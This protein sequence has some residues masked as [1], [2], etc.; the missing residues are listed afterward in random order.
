LIGQSCTFNDRE[1]FFIDQSLS[2]SGRT[3]L[4]IDE[5]PSFIGSFLR[6]NAL[7]GPRAGFYNGRGREGKRRPDND[8]CPTWEVHRQYFQSQV[9]GDIVG[10]IDYTSTGQRQ[11]T[12]F[13]YSMFGLPRLLPT[14]GVQ[15]SVCGAALRGSRPDRMA[16]T[17]AK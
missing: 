17:K 14:T 13:D 11:T 15:V 4:C 8:L 5:K 6:Q 10:V 9:T 1:R 2:F 12:R 7:A 3:W 16:V